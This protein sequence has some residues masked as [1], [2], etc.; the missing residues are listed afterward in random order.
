MTS[1]KTSGEK[2]NLYTLRGKNELFY[3]CGIFCII[4]G[5]LGRCGR[6]R[7]GRVTLAAHHHTAGH[8]AETQI[9]LSGGKS[10]HKRRVDP[11]GSDANKDRK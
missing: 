9:F 8:D 2:K 10:E 7:Q 11:G 6:A 4:K 5:H 3:Y 1:G